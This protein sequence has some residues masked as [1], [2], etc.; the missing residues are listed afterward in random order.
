MGV[1]E[2][3][4]CESA[5]KQTGEDSTPGIT[6]QPVVHDEIDRTHETNVKQLEVDHKTNARLPAS[7]LGR[8][9][10]PF[11]HKPDHPKDIEAKP[12]DV[13]AKLA[14]VEAKAGEAG[15][16]PKSVASTTEDVGEIGEA[17]RQ[18]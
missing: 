3:D 10:R 7:R 15:P 11:R 17:Q 8:V 14:D 12:T 18:V 6:E 9:L 4:F 5:G 2:E 13:D 1:R 16:E